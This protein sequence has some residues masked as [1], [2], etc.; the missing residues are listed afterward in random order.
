MADEGVHAAHAGQLL[1]W[2]HRRG[3]HV[4]HQPCGVPLPHSGAFCSFT[5]SCAA[6]SRALRLADTSSAACAAADALQKTRSSKLVNAS[7]GLLSCSWC[8]CSDAA[9]AITAASCCWQAITCMA[10][11][12]CSPPGRCA[13]EG[14]AVLPAHAA[15]R[16]PAGL[17]R[18]VLAWQR[19]HLRAGAWQHQRRR[20]LVHKCAPPVH[21]QHWCC[22]QQ[23]ASVSR[24]QSWQTSRELDCWPALPG[25][26]F[27][28]SDLTYE[29]GPGS[30]SV[31][32]GWYT[33]APLKCSFM[34][35]DV[36][37]PDSC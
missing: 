33:S 18:C 19:P 29:L 13:G 14:L 35:Q 5:C 26:S 25:S 17:K 34:S 27:S 12:A 20:R 11:L 32:G 28:G 9:A 8:C 30:T 3:P 1:L 6:A 16:L 36:S 4:A 2:H 37:R 21:S 31:A 22:A 10:P 23:L 24:Q 15:P 7:M